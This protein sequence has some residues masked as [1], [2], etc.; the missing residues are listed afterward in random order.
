MEAQSPGSEDKK[1]YIADFHLTKTY[2]RFTKY[3]RRYA[4]TKV[5]EWIEVNYQTLI[6]MS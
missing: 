3:W 1:H 4:Y 5:T 2:Q 6:P